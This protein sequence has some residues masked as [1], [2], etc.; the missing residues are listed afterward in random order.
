LTPVIF[1]FRYQRILDVKEK[2]ERAL[3]IE[4]GRVDRLIMEQEAVR[5]RWERTRQGTLEEMG[6]ARRRADLVENARCAAYLHYVRARLAQCRVALAELREERERVRRELQHVAQ[7]RELLEKYRDRLRAEFLADLEK[8]E[9]RV[10]E[11]HA[12]RKFTGS[13]E[14]P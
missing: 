4:L 3:E 10:L 8:A 6:V 14:R 2:Q 7:S 1:R 9:D 5:G 13:E 12:A 11:V